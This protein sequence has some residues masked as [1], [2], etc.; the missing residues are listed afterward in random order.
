MPNLIPHIFH[1]TVLWKNKHGEKLSRDVLVCETEKELAEKIAERKIPDEQHSN[2]TMYTRDLGTPTEHYTLFVSEIIATERNDPETL[3]TKELLQMEFSEYKASSQQTLQMYP[4]KTATEERQLKK[5]YELTPKIIAEWISEYLNFEQNKENKPVLFFYHKLDEYLGNHL[6][7]RHDLDMEQEAAKRLNQADKDA[8]TI[9]NKA[10]TEAAQYV[11]TARTEIEQEKADY[12]KEQQ[13]VMITLQEILTNA[14]SLSETIQTTFHDMKQELTIIK[15]LSQNQSE[16]TKSDMPSEN[17]PKPTET[18]EELS[19]ENETTT[20][21]EKPDFYQMFLQSIR[22][23]QKQK[24]DLKEISD[25]INEYPDE[26][27]ALIRIILDLW[28]ISERTDDL[29]DDIQKQSE[30]SEID[31]CACAIHIVQTQLEPEYLANIA[32][33]IQ[34]PILQKY[35]T[36]YALNKKSAVD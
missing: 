1:T 27:R 29:F 14:K 34:N 9:R 22:D 6:T 7:V 35:L 33:K 2:V 23:I 13:S 30:C 26:T 18:S 11:K 5:L 4:N 19:S 32:H 17:T 3:S 36:Q 24:P 28:S 20:E 31:I 25:C 10:K 8:D 16:T 12:K 21:T 15:M